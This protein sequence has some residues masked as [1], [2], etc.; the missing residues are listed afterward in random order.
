[1]RQNN[2]NQAING[3]NLLVFLLSIYV[4]FELILSSI[5]HFSSETQIL[6]RYIDNLIC[7]VFFFDFCLRFYQ[8]ENKLKFIRWG[9]ID[10]LASFPNVS[11][12][13]LGRLLQIFRIFRVIRAFR[14]MDQ[15][16][17]VFFKQKARGT[18]TTAILFSVLLI[19]F[20]SIAILQFETHPNSNIKTAE[21]ALWWVYVTITTV[22]YG[23]RYPVTREGRIL[24]VFLITCG[25]GLF[26]ALTAYIATWFVVDKK[27]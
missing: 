27:D 8:A 25:V 9:W 20:S 12:L 23:D 3:L 1:M 21:D 7:L 13:R 16:F 24:A 17:K 19:I 26:S 11:F 22:G 14:S 5:F 2:K 6:L 18:L 4:I 15:F 10:L